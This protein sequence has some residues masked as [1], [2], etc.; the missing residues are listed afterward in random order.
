MLRVSLPLVVGMAT[1]MVMEI[2]DRIFL[3]NYS[4]NAIAAA[5]PGGIMAFLFI[6]FFMGVAQYVNVFIAQYIGAD[7]KE[8]VAG[9]LWQGIYFSLVA[10]VL[11]AAFWPVAPLIFAISGHAPAVQ[12]LEGV[13]FRILCLGAGFFILSIALSCFFM[14]QGRTRPVMV[15]NIAGMVF[16]I[17]LNY[18]LIHGVWGAPELGIRGAGIATVAAWLLMAVLY[19]V[20]LFNR[21]NEKRF[22]LWRNRRFNRKLFI[23][24]M[25]FGVP[26]ALQFTLDISA[27]AIFVLM[28]GRLGTAELAAT[29]IVLSINSLAFMPMLGFSV[30]TSTL[31]GQALGRNRPD[32]AVAITRSTLILIY[33][34]ITGMALLFFFLPEWLLAAFT[35]GDRHPAEEA[36]I[37][38][39]GTVLLRFVTVYIFFDA[40]YAVYTGV[41]KGAGDT[42][43][44]M[45][46]IGAFSLGVLALP[47]YIGI[48]YFGGDLY[49][50]WAC[51]TVY[52]FSLFG[53]TLWRY[54]GG[55]W[56]RI[57][58]IQGIS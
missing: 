54:L 42:R 29:N 47:L 34:Y 19:G 18:A 2:T 57:R 32:D 21:A 46:T 53:V 44:I 39:M 13:Y 33:F 11:M 41:L 17:P 8:G 27:F 37:T 58:V 5:T 28:V 22:G 36:A 3:A 30:G 25:R 14:G 31:V 10:A 26:G 1:T 40:Q 23:R 20:L 4:L 16:N 7:Q 6:S 15:V 56:K 24:L 43:F 49:Y 45:W 50:A 51:I 38:R 9:A 35:A 12:A 48:R 55:E 52:I